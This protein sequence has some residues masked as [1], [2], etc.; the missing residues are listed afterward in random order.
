[1]S[2]LITSR[3]NPTIKRLAELREAK[4]RR[5]Q[6]SYLIDTPRDALRAIE[7]G[8]QILAAYTCPD[9][10]TP[11]ELTAALHKYKIP[12]TEISSTAYEVIAYRENPCGVILEGAIWGT[13]LADLPARDYSLVLIA[14]DIEKPGNLGTLLRTADAT[15]VQAIIGCNPSVDLFN[16]NTLRASAGAAF[17]VPYATAS[18]ADTLAWLSQLQIRLIGSSPAA[19]AL[20]WECDLT[21]KVAIAVG[22]E[23]WGLT[24]DLLAACHTQLKLPMLGSGDSLNV[25]VA[26]GA[27][28]YEALRQRQATKA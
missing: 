22:S 1:M 7:S 14:E 10:P 25:S 15:G 27:I 9:H 19:P 23:A 17:T 18:L 12:T 24:S 5:E 3:Q 13:F 11:P 2:V 8:R 21:A 26:T 4:G 20:L 16:P 6:G 28:L